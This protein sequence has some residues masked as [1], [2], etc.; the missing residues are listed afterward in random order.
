MGRAFARPDRGAVHVRRGRDAGDSL[1]SIRGKAFI[2]GAYEHPERELPDTSL[3]EVHADV[4]LGALAD[5]GL[6]L[7]DVDA[8]FCAADAPGFGAIS[9]AD[10]LGLKVR[11]TD[12]T[13]SGGSWYP[14]P[15]G[16][17]APARAAGKGNAG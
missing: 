1:M 3:A 8:Y 10:Y 17:A 15:A 2:A 13:E 7:S 12:S 6:G 9:L 16:T 4:A 14:G 5:A 11:Y